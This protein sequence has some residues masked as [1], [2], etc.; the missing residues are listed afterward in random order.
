MA[1]E[2]KTSES[3]AEKRRLPQAAKR[4][5][6][7]SDEDGDISEDSSNAD[8]RGKKPFPPEILA[9]LALQIAQLDPKGIPNRILYG[10]TASDPKLDHAFHRAMKRAEWLL[11]LAE[12]DSGEE[13]H[14][15]QVF[16]GDEDKTSFSDIA[17]RFKEAGWNGLA[18]RN[19]VEECIERI[20]IKADEE[21]EERVR[22]FYPIGSTGALRSSVFD[23]IKKHI[24]SFIEDFSL[25]DLIHDYD[26][27]VERTTDLVF[28]EICKEMPE[29]TDNEKIES[30]FGYRMFADHVLDPPGFNDFLNAGIAHPATSQEA[31]SREVSSR[32]TRKVRP[33]EI[34][35]FASQKG[36][37]PEKLVH[38]RRDLDSSFLPN[39]VY[40]S[41]LSILSHHR[42]VKRLLEEELIG[43]AI[44][45]Q[46]ASLG[47]IRPE[48]KS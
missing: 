5:D 9:S 4:K 27:F 23:G 26:L 38:K 2:R 28:R 41:S 36:L 43:L 40:N 42:G 6:N 22:F 30:C 3:K 11:K 31:S 15:Y 20:V 12:G 8:V 44:K 32:S 33:Y 1:E 37:L 19:S 17:N 34:F 35:L 25:G 7:H 47:V 10:V 14:A 18:S 48:D 13:V 16:S 39:P 45:P 24:N 46:N 21:I 29:T